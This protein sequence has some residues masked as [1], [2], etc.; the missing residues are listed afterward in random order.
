MP[1]AATVFVGGKD[2]TNVVVIVKEGGL[3]R[4]I[5]RVLDGVPH[6]QPLVGAQARREV[7]RGS[8]VHDG[9]VSSGRARGVNPSAHGETVLWADFLAQVGGTG[10]LCASELEGRVVDLDLVA[11]NVSGRGGR[12]G[13]G[14]LRWSTR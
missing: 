4:V 8:E 14:S 9:L 3:A 1:L 2:R 13:I 5:C 10:L 6:L 12:V 11:A 7:P